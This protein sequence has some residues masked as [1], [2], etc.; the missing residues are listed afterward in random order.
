MHTVILLTMLGGMEETPALD[1]VLHWNEEAL[2]AIRV[3]KTP[4]PLAAR[5]L[6]MVHAAVYDAVNAVTRT[7][8]AYLIDAHPP[9]GTSAEVAATVAAH[10]VLI[11]LYPAQ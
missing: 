1:P 10:R 4:P 8:S 9:Q 5:N 7:H 3:A 11:E 6:A 2:Q